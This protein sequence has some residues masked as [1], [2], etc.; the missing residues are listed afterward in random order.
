MRTT[1]QLTVGIDGRFLQDKFHGV[2]RYTY[3]LLT[4]LCAI[5]G[6]HRIIVFVDPSLPNSRFPL[7]DLVRTGRVEF[8]HISIPLYGA[9]ELW[10]WPL[11]LRGAPVDVF[12]APFFW[13]PLVLPC[14]LITTVHDMIFD[15]YPQYIPGLR[16]LVPYRLSSRLAMKKAQYVLSPSEATKSDIVRFANVNGDKIVSIPSGIDQRF[17]PISSET[18]R[19][20]VRQAYALP[21]SYVLALGARRPHKNI[22]RLVS[23]FRQIMD[24]TTQSLVLVGFID[25]RF[26]DRA[27]SEIAE[28]RQAG[29]LVE[30][31]HV[32]EEDLPA[33][34]AM[35]DLFVQ[36]SIIEGFGFPVLEALAC[37]CPVACSNTSSLPEVAGD[38]AVLFN[39]RSTEDIA[40]AMLRVVGSSSLRE[41]LCRRGVTQARRFSWESTAQETLDIYRGAAGQN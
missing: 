2:G 23:A 27:A 32:A 38:A 6:N 21:S 37:G 33:V 10:A 24:K 25:D 40:D 11:V 34:Y 30:I 3:G 20:R 22:A 41:S 13:S 12:H 35:A 31:A 26:T 28:L 17:H 7:Q 1:G 16:Y 36:P 5:E 14:P 19:F 4:G 8:R 29:R 39:P 9:Q 18:E 15:H